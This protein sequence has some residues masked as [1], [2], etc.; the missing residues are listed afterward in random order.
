MTEIEIAACPSPV[1]EA[2]LPLV[3]HI[4]EKPEAV[5]FFRRLVL[6]PY[7]ARQNVGFVQLPVMAAHFL[8]GIVVRKRDCIRMSRNTS[9][10][11]TV[12]LYKTCFDAGVFGD[13]S[14]CHGDKIRICFF[15]SVIER[16]PHNAHKGCIF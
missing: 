2:S 6:L 12:C 10:V 16:P 7:P 14:V 4:V 15:E 1:Y 9:G 3:S 5:H 13:I 8:L 11:R